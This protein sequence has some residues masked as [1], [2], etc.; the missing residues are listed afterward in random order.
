MRGKRSNES[1]DSTLPLIM[2]KDDSNNE[3]LIMMMMMNEG[4]QC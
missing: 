1:M 4:K 3:S 2:M